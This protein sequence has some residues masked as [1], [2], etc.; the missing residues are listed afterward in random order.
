MSRPHNTGRRIFTTLLVL[1]FTAPHPSYAETTE[2][3]AEART[4]ERVVSTRVVSRKIVRRKVVRKPSKRARRRRAASDARTI[5]V[6]HPTKPKPAITRTHGVTTQ[7]AL[8]RANTFEEPGSLEGSRS[9]R[10]A[11][12]DLIVP[13]PRP[14]NR[15]TI[16]L[17]AMT[18]VPL[19]IGAGV[20]LESKHRLRLRSSLGFISGAY[21]D[22]VNAFAQT[23]SPQPYTDAVAELVSESLENSMVWRTHVGMRPGERAGLYMHAGYT[24]VS[25]G[26]KTTGAELLEAALEIGD[27]DM[28]SGP[29]GAARDVQID[30]N[31]HLVDVEL[32]WDFYVGRHANLRIGA[33]YSHTFFSKT[34]ISARYEADPQM[35]TAELQE[36]ERNG[37][38]LLDAI[39]QEYLRFPTVSMAFGLRF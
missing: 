8:A 10:V 34:R 1:A 22:G 35:S 37:E 12:Q 24:L 5:S 16:R 20:M 19:Q 39:Y 32:G 2:K 28:S 15:G 18:D 14:R 38:V 6:E 29:M 23:Y 36:M 11:K 30:S 27:V 26:S 17:E 9:Q 4:N 33:G 3:E 21:I 25:F 7:P 31:L 13:A